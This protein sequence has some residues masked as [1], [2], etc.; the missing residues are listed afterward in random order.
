MRSCTAGRQD[1]LVVVVSCGRGAGFLLG[2]TTYGIT[3][4]PEHNSAGEWVTHLLPGG[5]Q[6]PREEVKGQEPKAKGLR[7]EQ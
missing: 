7:G 1:A 3:Q 4:A 5:R 2:A 6:Q